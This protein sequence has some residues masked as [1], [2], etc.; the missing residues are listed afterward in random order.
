MV[1]V[2]KWLPILAAG[3]GPAVVAL[4]Y[5]RQRRKDGPEIMR[6]LHQVEQRL[7]SYSERRP[8]RWY[9]VLVITA[10]FALPIVQW[11]AFLEYRTRLSFLLPLAIVASLMLT[12]GAFFPRFVVTGSPNHRDIG[13]RGVVLAAAL[14]IT[15][16]LPSSGM[17]T[18]LRGALVDGLALYSVSYLIRLWNSPK[19]NLV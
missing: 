13:L 10:L 7:P 4:T 15:L 12:V 11:F 1:S 6:A 14:V 5:A 9:H 3:A 8:L 17:M 18:L 16:A 2:A 19:A